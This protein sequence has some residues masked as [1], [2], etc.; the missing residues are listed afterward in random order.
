VFRGLTVA[1][2]LLVNDPGSWSHIYPPLRHAAWHGWTPTDLIF[3]FFLF[4]MGV[5]THLS[6]TRRRARG[7]TEGQLRWQVLRRGGVIVLLGLL[8][9]AFPFFPPEWITQARIPGVLQRI[10]VV[11]LVSGFLVLGTSLRTQVAI[12]A[13]ILAGYWLLLAAVP[14]PGVG[15]A[16]LA[17][18]EAT[19]AAWVDRLL[20]DGHL[21]A[22]TR[23]WDPE[24]PLSTLPAI[25]TCLIG[26]LAGRWITQPRPLAER[27]NGLFVSGIVGLAVGS[28]WSWVFPINKN[29]WTS[30]YVVFTAG[31]AC[32]ALGTCMWLIE[33][34]SPRWWARPFLVFGVNP[35]VAFVGAEA[36][37]RLLYSVIRVSYQGETV[38][39]QAAIYRSAFAFWLPPEAA[40]LAFAVAFVLVWYVVLDLLYRRGVVIRI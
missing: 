31:M 28:A 16:A 12:I 30:S 25:A 35:I 33:E 34:R 24:G 17:P 4:I 11:Y 39:L 5:T 7:A 10:G 26:V 3:P 21:W 8:L 29:L 19:L 22:Q 18:P 20:L 37:A 36:T 38:P 13:G 1:A 23:T 40:S 27:L 6:L 15:G 32:Q 9:S 14:V 2:M